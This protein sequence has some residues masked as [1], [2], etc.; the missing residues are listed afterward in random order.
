MDFLTNKLIF[1]F[2][3]YFKFSEMILYDSP[4]VLGPKSSTDIV[5]L[6][7]LKKIEKLQLMT[8]QTTPMTC[9]KCGWP[10]CDLKCQSGKSHQKECDILANAIEK[11]FFRNF[12]IFEK[13][14]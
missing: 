13:K 6:Q 5:C 11:V 3:H 12:R 2:K 10:V 9:Q 8:S 4:A 7:C 1:E 14:N